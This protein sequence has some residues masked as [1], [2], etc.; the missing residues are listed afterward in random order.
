MINAANA[1]LVFFGLL[2]IVSLTLSGMSFE[3]EED[4]VSLTMVLLGI[5]SFLIYTF[6]LIT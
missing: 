2:T 4:R 6:L 5:A 3:A 1:L